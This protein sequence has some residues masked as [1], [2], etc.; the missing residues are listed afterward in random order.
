MVQLRKRRRSEERRWRLR[1]EKR[2][3]ALAGRKPFLVGA[4][5]DKGVDGFYSFIVGG[6]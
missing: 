6:V 5:V 3:A 4:A 1:R 2:E